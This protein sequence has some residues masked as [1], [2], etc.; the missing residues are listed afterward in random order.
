MRQKLLYDKVKPQLFALM[1]DI[2]LYITLL[3]KLNKNAYIKNIKS[4]HFYLLM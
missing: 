4:V 1:G 2:H 3:K